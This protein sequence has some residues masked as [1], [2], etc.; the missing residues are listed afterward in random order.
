MGFLC[1]K[2]ILKKYTK[3]NIVATLTMGHFLICFTNTWATNYNTFWSCIRVCIFKF[4][5][6]LRFYRNR[7]S[8]TLFFRCSVL[9]LSFLYIGVIFGA[10]D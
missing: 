10:R 2:N 1:R 7:P 6:F 9:A 5:V 8:Q 3:I 4:L